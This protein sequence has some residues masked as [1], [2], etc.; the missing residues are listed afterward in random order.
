MSSLATGFFYY[1]VIIKALGLIPEPQFL[2]IL[3][4]FVAVSSST[5]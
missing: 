2:L 4:I 5:L 3:A 1:A